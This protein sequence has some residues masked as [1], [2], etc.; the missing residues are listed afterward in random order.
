LFIFLV[1]WLP[2]GFLP[3]VLKHVQLFTNDGKDNQGEVRQS[4]TPLSCMRAPP[5]FINLNNF[6]KV[7]DEF[8]HIVNLGHASE[9][10]WGSTFWGSS[11]MHSTSILASNG[12]AA[13]WYVERA[14]NGAGKSVTQTILLTWVA[15][16]N[17]VRCQITNYHFLIK[18]QKYF[19]KKFPD[20]CSYV[21]NWSFRSLNVIQ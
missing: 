9:T 19:I 21:K 15:N 8:L 5:T 16:C 6:W 20:T 12:N 4:R 14:G 18:G 11:A 17:D 3:H 2:G 1:P 7:P 10:G 13:T